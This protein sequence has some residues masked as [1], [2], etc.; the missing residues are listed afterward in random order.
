MTLRDFNKD[1]FF[2]WI[3]WFLCA[4]LHAKKVA[5]NWSKTK[6]SCFAI[7]IRA[8]VILSTFHLKTFLWIL[9][10]NLIRSFKLCN[11]SESFELEPCF[12]M[13]LHEHRTTSDL[14]FWK[15]S[16]RIGCGN[17]DSSLQ[18]D[19]SENEF[20]T[21]QIAFQNESCLCVFFVWIN[22]CALNVSINISL[23]H[24]ESVSFWL[25]HQFCGSRITLT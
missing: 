19:S 20:L 10:S 25:R 13:T 12:H 16:Y 1:L 7:N 18:F 2:H 22:I 9:I 6:W 5:I 3:L 15:A 4:S 23:R 11:H 17:N 14:N 8:F 24:F 21:A